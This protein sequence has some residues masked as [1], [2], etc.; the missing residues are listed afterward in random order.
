MTMAPDAIQAEMPEAPVRRV[1]IMRPGLTERLAVVATC[2][3]LLNGL[4][5]T[6]FLTRAQVVQSDGSNALLVVTEMTLISLAL[7]RIAGSFE[8]LYQT[9]R[10]EPA[11]SLLVGLALASLFWSANLYL[12]LKDGVVLAA[13]TLYAAYLVIRFALNEIL[14]LLAAMFVLSAAVNLAFVLA[15]PRYAADANGAWDGVF[16]QKNALGFAAAVA[17]PVLITVA[18]EHT[19]FAAV[20]YTAAIAQLALLIGS[21]SKT[22]LVAASATLGLMVVYRGFQA[23]RTLRGAVITGLASASAFAAAFATANIALLSNLLDKDVTLTGRTILWQDLFPIFLDR[24]F[25]GYGYSGAF[26]GYFSPIHEVW[27][28]NRWDPTHAHNAVLQM[29]LELGIAGIVVYLFLFGR[30]IS[31]AIRSTRDNPGVVGRW[32]LAFLSLALLI[33]ISESG[34]L[35]NNIAWLFFC[36]AVVSV[37]ADQRMATS[38]PH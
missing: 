14:R 27:I 13:V 2:F 37:G 22:M 20:Y 25:L 33:S 18:R 28:Q 7:M 24:P 3:I 12:T 19:R 31:R 5:N 38:S 6:W 29:G 26:D 23:R 30:S 36:I 35:S 10:I 17:L 11:L 21:E 8:I 9:L 32:P 1:V 34:V 16:G 4:P 15:L